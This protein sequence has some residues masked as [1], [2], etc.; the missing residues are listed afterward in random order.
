MSKKFGPYGNV[1]KRVANSSPEEVEWYVKQRE[2]QRFHL[3]TI[4]AGDLIEYRKPGHKKYYG[5]VLET[6][7]EPPRDRGEPGALRQ[8]RV[9]WSTEI[10]EADDLPT[11]ET[12]WFN[13]W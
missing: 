11:E 13:V 5:L 6:R 2:I 10:T 9:Q 12:H 4:R 3:H 7:T 1:P 8:L